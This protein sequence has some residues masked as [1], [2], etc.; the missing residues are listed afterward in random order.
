MRAA[1]PKATKSLNQVCAKRAWQRGLDIQ[2]LGEGGA[3]L[4][5]AEARFGL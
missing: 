2:I 1:P 5:E 3:V 4:D